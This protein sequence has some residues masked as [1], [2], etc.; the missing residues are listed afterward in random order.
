[1]LSDA[2]T[3][4]GVNSFKSTG[5]EGLNFA[6]SVDDII[7]FISRNTN[8]EAAASEGDKPETK[9]QTACEPK[10]LFTS[11][12]KA[13]DADVTGFD[14][15]CTGE[16][17]AEL[18]RPD[19][20]GKPFLFLVD[21][22]GDKKTD[23][24]IFDFKREGKWEISLWDENFDGHWTLVGYHPNGSLVPSRFESYETFKRRSGAVH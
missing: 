16:A 3:I 11:R 24:M 4:I 19:D 23:V 21:R 9:S 1:L 15:K 7:A 10:E 6:V 20:T 2:G 17:D 5:D 18:V 8:R 22:N 13:N 12:N 14:F